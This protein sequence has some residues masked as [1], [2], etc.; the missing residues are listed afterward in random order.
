MTALRVFV[1]REL[2][3]FTAGGIGRVVAN[4]LATS[5][6]QERDNTAILYVGDGLDP[7]A[8]AAVYPGVRLH[9]SHMGTYQTVDARGRRYPAYG[10]FNNTVLHWE[11]VLILQGLRALQES[12]GALGYVEFVDWGAAAFAATQEKLLGNDFL[13]TTLAVRLHTTDSILADFEPRAQSIHGL[14]LYDLERKALAD[15]DLI[16]AQL[17]PV[18]EAFRAFY[19][20]EDHDWA[21]R[22]CVHSPPVLLDSLPFASR[23]VDIGPDTPL[24]FTSKLQDI[25][26]PDVFIRGCVQ[27]MRDNPAY[28]GN[29]VFL[30]HSFD[31]AYQQTIV[32]MIPADLVGR[33]VFAKGV[34]GAPREKMIAESV[35]IFPSPWESFCLAAYEASLS[36]AICVLN[37]RNPAFGDDT[38]WQDGINCIKF[39]GV[40]ADLAKALTALFSGSTGELLPVT[41]ASTAAPWALR[42]ESTEWAESAQP[43]L[44]AVVINQGEGRALMP[45]IDSLLASACLIEEIII[46]DDASPDPISREVLNRL[47]VIDPRVRVVRFPVRSGAAAARNA[48]L[49]AVS[50]DYV[51]FLRA[52]EQLAPHYLG[53]AVRGLSRH[54]DF[55]VVVS[56]HGVATALPAVGDPAPSFDVCHVH[57]GEA[58][59]AGLYENRLGPDSFVIRTDRA[60][61]LGFDEAVPANETWEMLLRACQQEV[62]FIASSS[63]DITSRPAY[64]LVSKMHG[65]VSG[66][67]LEAQRRLLHGKRAQLGSIKV[68]AYVA[69]IQGSGGAVTLLSLDES[70][71]RLQELLDSET[72]RYTLAL[73][74]LLQRRAPWVLRMG[75]RLIER[76]LPLYRRFR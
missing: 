37:D 33:V 2:Y 11:S 36:G 28:Q 45:S 64:P 54:S 67:V 13:Q 4:I 65:D 43:R 25:K 10:S 34:N 22:S 56:H 61:A 1:T 51:V 23:S 6:Q 70:S 75:K 32:D 30:A 19:G 12:E 46:V 62:R 16:V 20:F 50:C 8:F 73:A 39:N 38:P 27:F 41:Q 76:L 53:A 9:V 21:A 74:N 72:V 57:Y 69:A 47:E 26:R 40:P 63:I 60:R 55:D 3:P 18:S 68:P 44:G 58:R 35:C 31:A 14:S 17:A 52:G 29:V 48:G 66:A 24:L 42:A 49:E 5:T 59:L 7:S 15:C 71:Y